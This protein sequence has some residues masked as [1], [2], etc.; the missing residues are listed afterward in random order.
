M[1]TE[2][3]PQAAPPQ[4]PRPQAPA[5]HPLGSKTTSAIL[6]M[7]V[8]LGVPYTSSKLAR[9]RVARLPGVGAVTKEPEVG[10]VASAPVLAQ[11]E[12][13]LLAS[14]NEATV[15]NAL[16]SE[17]ARVPLDPAVLAKTAGSLAVEDPTGHE[18]D[19]FYASLARTEAKEPGA[20]TRVMHYGDSVIT[21]DYVSG[22]MRRKL[23][24]RYGDSG[25]GFILIANPWEW[26]F[27]NDVV[28]YAQ[29]GWSSSRITGPLSKD[30][31]YGLGGVSFVGAP[32]ASAT[33]GTVEKGKY[34]TQVSRFDLYYLEQPTG[35]DAT[36]AIAGGETTKLSTRGEQKVSR[37]H[38]VTIPDGPGKLTLRATGNG[39]LRVFGVALERDTPGVVYDALGANGAR[40]KLWEGMDT[41]HWTEQMALRKPALVVLQFGTNESEDGWINMTEYEKTVATIVGRVKAAAPMAS[42]LVASPLDRAEKADDGSFRTKKVIVRLSEGQRK[43]AKASG[44]AFWDTFRAMG[45]EG[46]MARWVKATPQLGSWDLTHPTPT[47]AEVIGDLFVKSLTSGFEAYKSRAPHSPLP[48]NVPVPVPVPGPPSPSSSA[49]AP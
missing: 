14:K 9:F 38:S 15:S 11:G 23:Q 25:H 40:M 43:A 44:A 21:S 42:V 2:P 13:V 33:F 6:V 36:L 35:G 16:P 39:P 49:K 37:V 3:T 48:V 24:E 5:V 22:T 29:E 7:L 1:A 26:Y 45:G 8:L 47:G 41:A 18:M 12:T 10:P 31:T 20:I 4:A 17:P 30:G 34:G 19:A 32:G 46:S 27:H 28:H